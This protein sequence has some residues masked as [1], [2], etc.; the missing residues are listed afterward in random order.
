MMDLSNLLSS[1]RGYFGGDNQDTLGQG[2][3]IHGQITDDPSLLTLLDIGNYLRYGKGESERVEDVS[4]LRTPGV[5]DAAYPHSISTPK[6]DFPQFDS[7]AA[8]RYTSAYNFGNM[9]HI[10]EFLQPALHSIS[11]GGR[12]GLNAI[13]FPGVGEERPELENAEQLGMSRGAQNANPIFQDV[14][15]YNSF[16]SSMGSIFPSFTNQNDVTY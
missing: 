15:P 9:Y 1:M 16:M 10:P 3:G 11:S 4:R 6:G 2:R 14:D 8:E 12:Q 7:A 13:G 5:R